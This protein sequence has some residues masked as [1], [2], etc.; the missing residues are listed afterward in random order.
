M[1][2]KYCIST[3][4][5][6]VR[7]V[8]AFRISVA[9]VAKSPIPPVYY[10]LPQCTTYYPSVLPITPV[11]Y[12]LP[13]CTTY[14]PKQRHPSLRSATSLSI[15]PGETHELLVTPADTTLLSGVWGEC[16]KVFQSTTALRRTH[17]MF[18][19]SDF[20]SFHKFLYQLTTS[21]LFVKKVAEMHWLSAACKNVYWGHC[22]LV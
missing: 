18:S 10:L 21:V 3:S 13:Q 12:L 11:Y 6:L 8:L 15:C 16:S 17:N 1:S 2:P 4:T 22:C 14:Y 5:Y 9:M 19:I 7:C 20:C